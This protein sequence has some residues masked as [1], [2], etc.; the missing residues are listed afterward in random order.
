MFF[1]VLL[2]SLEIRRVTLGSVFRARP[3][4]F[5]GRLTVFGR[6]GLG[7]LVV[8]LAAAA[9]AAAALRRRSQDSLR[10]VVLCRVPSRLSSSGE[11]FAEFSFLFLFF[12][13]RP[14]NDGVYFVVVVVVVVVISPVL[15][16]AIVG[17]HRLLLISVFK[18]FFFNSARGCFSYCCFCFRCL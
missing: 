1:F 9:A 2:E 12:L 3:R 6:C 15:S 16:V 7:F 10:T 14:G 17:L 11:C 5:N 4:V 18:G 13:L 8:F